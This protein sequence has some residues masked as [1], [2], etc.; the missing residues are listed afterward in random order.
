MAPTT[1]APLLDLNVD[2]V[3]PRFV[4]IDGQDYV[5]RGPDDLSIQASRALARHLRSYTEIVAVQE[6]QGRLSRA[7]EQSLD[8][9]LKTICPMVLDAPPRVLAKLKPVHRYRVVNV[10]C[11]LS[12]TS[13][14]SARATA[15]SGR[16]VP[17][18]QPGKTSSQASSVSTVA[19]RSRGG[20][21]TRLG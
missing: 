14:A 11:M 21:S 4:R 15:V 1:S 8:R 10:F 12:L 18:R 19:T 9:L 3:A 5:L 6:K 13:L 7:A 20:A 2:N 16:P 17:P